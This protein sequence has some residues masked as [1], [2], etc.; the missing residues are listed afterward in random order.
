MKGGQ[1]NDNIMLVD[2][3]GH[4]GLDYHMYVIGSLFTDSCHIGTG[5]VILPF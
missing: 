2:Y 5:K 1:S 4:N 3:L